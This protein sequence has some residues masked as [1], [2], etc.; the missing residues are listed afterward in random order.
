MPVL[1]K[2]D[3][4]VV[5]VP[6]LDTGLAFYA[7]VLGHSLRWRYDAIGQAALACPDS[8]VELV[9]STGHDHHPVWLVT[10]L[11]EAVK[12][13]TSGG[14]HLV[15]APEQIPVGR[16]AVVEDPFGNPLVLIELTGRYDVSA[17]G[18]VQAV[19]PAQ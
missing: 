10:D 14:G 2:L 11:T 8:D 5:R 9:L 1:R 13:T 6:D 4:V 15:S 7:D 18:D 19:T 12:L 3:A 17:L 16:L